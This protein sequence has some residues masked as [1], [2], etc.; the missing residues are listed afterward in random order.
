MCY[1][2]PGPST[3]TYGQGWNPS[4]ETT[5][6]GHRAPTSGDKEGYKLQKAMF[7][8]LMWPAVLVTR[9]QLDAVALLSGGSHRSAAPTAQQP[10]VLGWF[11]GS[12]SNTAIH[13]S[14]PDRQQQACCACPVL[15][16]RCGTLAGRYTPLLSL[17]WSW[18]SRD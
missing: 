18:G 8:M 4:Q 3:A 17:P 2:S 13:A 11:L 9:L 6:L 12:Q 10:S 14:S 7:R 16:S 1:H 15:G 5:L